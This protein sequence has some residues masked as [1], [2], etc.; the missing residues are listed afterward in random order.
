MSRDDK[1]EV[2]KL[3]SATDLLS[4]FEHVIPLFGPQF[5]HLQCEETELR[6]TLRALQQGS[7]RQQYAEVSYY[8]IMKIDCKIWENFVDLLL[9][10]YYKIF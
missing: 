7:L 4:K 5:S 10:R 2:G 3:G 1:I 6:N 9:N 8:W